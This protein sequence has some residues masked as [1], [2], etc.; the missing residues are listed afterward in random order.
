MEGVAPASPPMPGASAVSIPA[1]GLRGDTAEREAV[2]IAMRSSS[3]AR[4]PYPA[5]QRVD[6]GCLAAPDAAADPVLPLADQPRTSESRAIASVIERRSAPVALRDWMRA[7]EMPGV[8]VHVQQGDAGLRVWL[9]VDMQD[10]QLAAQAAS[11]LATVLAGSGSA[12]HRLAALV[13]NGT[14][15]YADSRPIPSLPS[16][17]QPW[18]SAH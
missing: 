5:A 10:P 16:Q 4:H 18:P 8:R 3:V 13:C 14:T 2:T 9:G 11:I 7:P 1:H 6:G 12:T 15:L 17:E